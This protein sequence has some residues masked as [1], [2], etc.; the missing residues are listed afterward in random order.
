L[1]GVAHTLAAVRPM[2]N[3]LRVY[4]STFIG[5][6]L[7]SMWGEECLTYRFKAAFEKA[8]SYLLDIAQ[9]IK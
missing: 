9:S 5:H 8:A 7:F 4:L 1:K 3:L 6:V 2:P